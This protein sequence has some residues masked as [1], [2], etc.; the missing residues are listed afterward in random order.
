MSLGSKSFYFI[1]GGCRLYLLS[2]PKSLYKAN[3]MN[4]VDLKLHSEVYV[5]WYVGKY[6]AILTN[7]SVKYKK[8]K[9]CF[10]KK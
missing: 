10:K 8:E 2:E 5:F 9:S 4:S 1:I 7:I 3:G 6:L